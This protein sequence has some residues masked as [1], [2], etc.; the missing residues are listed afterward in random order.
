MLYLSFY[1][2]T[3]I[4]KK[5]FKLKTLKFFIIYSCYLQKPSFQALVLALSSISNFFIKILFIL[6]MRFPSYINFRIRFKSN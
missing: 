6:L 1:K 5:S 3:L 2:E 4:K